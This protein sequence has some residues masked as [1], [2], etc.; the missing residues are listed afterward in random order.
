MDQHRR[1]LDADPVGGGSKKLIAGVRFGLRSP[2][3]RCDDCAQQ[4]KR[5]CHNAKGYR[6]PL[7]R[8]DEWKEWP[9]SLRHVEK[10]GDLKLF[11]CPLSTI[12][13]QT[14]QVLRI[15][16]QTT[17]ADGCIRQLPY[18]GAY[19]DQPLW[20]RQAVEIVT[21]ERAEHR[22]DEMEKRRGR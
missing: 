20:Y 18:P 9:A 13:A 17:D 15:V 22:K 5:N 4:T 6:D 19:L 12:T 16:N 1:L 2:A 21:K 10:W 8:K 7:A 11:A 14:W 3:Y